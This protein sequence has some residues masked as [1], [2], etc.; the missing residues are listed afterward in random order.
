MAL[1][2]LQRL[3]TLLKTPN[4]SPQRWTLEESRVEYIV[5]FWAE[6]RQGGTDICRGDNIA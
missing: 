4:V 6:P 2:R 3:L 1:E 5:P